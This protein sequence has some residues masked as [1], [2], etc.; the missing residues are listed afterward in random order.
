[1]IPQDELPL[2]NAE[3]EPMLLLD[4]TGSM[5]EATSATDPTP[6][7]DTVREAIGILVSKLAQQDSQVL[8]AL[9]SVPHAALL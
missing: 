9:V 1:M 3:K 5:N 4:V 6:R 2:P 7:K 8:A